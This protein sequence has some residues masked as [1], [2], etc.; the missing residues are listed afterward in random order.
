MGLGLISP[1]RQS[2]SFLRLPPGTPDRRPR[3]HRLVDLALRPSFLVAVRR[4]E[5]SSSRPP[6]R[7]ARILETAPLGTWWASCTWIDD[8]VS[9]SRIHS[10]LVL[11]LRASVPRALH[12]P[13]VMVAQWAGSPVVFVWDRLNGGAWKSPNFP[14]GFRTH[15]G[16]GF[17]LLAKWPGRTSE[18]GGP[19]PRGSGGEFPAA[20]AHPAEGPGRRTG[21]RSR[22]C[23]GSIGLRRLSG[24]E[25][26]AGEAV[27]LWRH[28]YRKGSTAGP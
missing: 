16:H 23:P 22:P 2:R 27:G 15:S 17:A 1:L 25:G 8:W 21:D 12:R 24:T 14:D 20:W 4:N 7:I 28:A 13:G 6:C 10:H 18:E 3:R 5:G 19:E 9:G 11:L 26:S